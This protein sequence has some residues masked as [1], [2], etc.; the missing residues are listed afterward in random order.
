MS[1]TSKRTQH[2]DVF[3]VKSVVPSR[4]LGRVRMSCFGN[5]MMQYRRRKLLDPIF[6]WRTLTGVKLNNNCTQYFSTEIFW[7]CNQDTELELH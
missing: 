1:P 7:Q 4:Q 3:S 6:T 2:Q 5:C